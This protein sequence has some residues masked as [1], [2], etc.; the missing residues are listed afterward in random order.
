[1]TSISEKISVILER[2]LGYVTAERDKREGA[3][4]YDS[5]K[6][7]AEEIANMQL[8]A[9][10]VNT[11]SKVIT[12]TEDDLEDHVAD[13]DIERLA[14]TKGKVII[15]AFS[16]YV[17]ESSTSN[18]TMELTAGAELS[19]IDLDTN[20]SFVV[21]DKVTDSTIVSKYT[22]CYYAESQTAGL[23]SGS[24]D[25]A[26]LQ[27]TT[28]INGLAYA[29]I[30]T[31][32]DGG[33]ETES[34]K[35][36][37]TR[38]I[39][40]CSY[41]GFGGNRSQYIRL[42]TEREDL[43]SMTHFQLYT[44][45]GGRVVISALDTNYAKFGSGTLSGFMDILDPQIDNYSGT[46][47]GEAPIGHR[48]I[49]CSPT[50]FTISIVI[51]GASQNTGFSKEAAELNFRTQ[52]ATLIAELQIKWAKHNDYYQ[53]EY[54][55]VE[56]VTILNRMTDSMSGTLTVNGTVVEST[57]GDMP[58]GTFVVPGTSTDQRIENGAI[59]TAP[60]NASCFPR[61]TESDISITWAT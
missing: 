53:Y 19:T 38:Y 61:C 30:Y 55:V 12:A 39:D 25:G 37:R 49:V 44:G 48:V 43:R 33:T 18:V 50:D 21:G 52:I 32:D 4:I 16:T 54:N 5:I 11:Q 35:D 15:V 13:M 20:Y 36:L 56:L 2:M 27:Q 6:P 40:A 9:D 34:D 10:E 28:T 47:A 3:V 26:E 41:E 58:F 23:L 51:T 57:S 24:L 59:I 7:A 42:I 14:A 22:H 1:M 60:V 31:I 17:A 45:A 46:G 29:M 8:E